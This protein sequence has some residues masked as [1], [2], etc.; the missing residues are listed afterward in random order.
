MTSLNKGILEDAVSFFGELDRMAVTFKR[1]K[2]WIRPGTAPMFY[3]DFGDTSEKVLY[4]GMNPSITE[5]T[6]SWFTGLHGSADMLNL[7][8]YMES[9]MSAQKIAMNKLIEFQA[10]LKGKAELPGGARRIPYFT[11]L[12]NFH[13]SVYGK[14][15]PEWE[16][17]DIFSYR[18]TYQDHLRKSFLKSRLS[19]SD[20]IKGLFDSSIKR[21]EMLVET[22]RFKSVVVLNS[23]ASSYLKEHKVLGLDR[24]KNGT[25]GNIIL[26]KQLLGGGT[27]KTER[28]EL[29]SRLMM[30]SNQV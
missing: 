24:I 20:S 21:F 3:P 10:A 22:N 16:H 25:M 18:S 30:L 15:S 5:K 8:H 6:V 9:D 14:S 29:T 1:D 12:C 28:T 2:D 17:Y 7:K 4:V 23:L 13:A 26:A 27:T 19:S 11:T